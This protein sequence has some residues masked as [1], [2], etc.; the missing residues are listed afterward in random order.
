[1]AK[2]KRNGNRK[3]PSAM[4][5]IGALIILVSWLIFKFSDI[6]YLLSIQSEM[7]GVG[8]VLL[9]IGIIWLFFKVR[10]DL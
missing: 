4:I 10:L 8:M 7:A 1:M 6:G 2:M 5:L 3:I 9:L